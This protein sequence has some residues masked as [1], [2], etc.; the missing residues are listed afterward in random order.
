[1]TSAD[2]YA[3]FRIRT[4]TTENALSM[5]DLEEWYGLTP[6]T[7]TVAMQGSAS[8]WVCEVDKEIVG[9]AMGDAD[10]GELTVLA[11]L[12]EYEG[13]GIGKQL[14]A[15]VEQWLFGLGHK[16]LWLMTTPDPA[17]RA[18]NLYTSQG[19]SP[20]GEIDD[21]DEKFLKSRLHR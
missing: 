20:T 14:L 12:P 9:F 19:W 11:V 10:E 16:E 17:L 3:A 2:I 15:E 13:K 7:L 18:Y 5:Q 21:E 1:M 8:G 4:S 6:A